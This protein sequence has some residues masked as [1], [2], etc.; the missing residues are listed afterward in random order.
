MKSYFFHLNFLGFR[1]PPPS[2]LIDSINRPFLRVSIGAKCRGRT[3]ISFPRPQLDS[4]RA[5]AGLPGNTPPLWPCDAPPSPP[6]AHERCRP[7]CTDAEGRQGAIV[8]LIDRVWWISIGQKCRKAVPD[9]LEF[10]PSKQPSRPGYQVPTSGTFESFVTREK[11][12]L[13]DMRADGAQM[14]RR[15]ARVERS[16]NCISKPVPADAA[17]GWRQGTY[18]TGS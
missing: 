6:L 8:G 3:P 4:S 14:E 13:T 5:S 2:P 16:R 7:G 18:A 10:C 9:L 11:D 17:G 15:D 12:I 1:R